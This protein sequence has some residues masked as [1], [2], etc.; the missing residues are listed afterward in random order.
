M[1]GERREEKE[2]SRLKALNENGD[3]LKDDIEKVT[4]WEDSVEKEKIV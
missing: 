4:L 3:Y 1:I 2:G